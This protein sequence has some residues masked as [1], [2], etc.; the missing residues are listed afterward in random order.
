MNNVSII[1]IGLIGSSIARAIKDINNQAEINIVDSN[2]S[3]LKSSEHLALGKSYHAAINQ[4]LEKSEFI[5]ICTPISTYEN[6]F[7]ELNKL[8]LDD[9]IITD[10]GSS[11]IQLFWKIKIIQIFYFLFFLLPLFFMGLTKIK[12]NLSKVY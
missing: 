8:K 3:N 6:I 1:G 9:C 12:I 7:L 2:V 5:F 4:E 10:V 11:K